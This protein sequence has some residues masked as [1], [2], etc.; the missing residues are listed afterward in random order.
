[1][2]FAL[3]IFTILGSYPIISS[4][5]WVIFPEVTATPFC[6]RLAFLSA[7][8]ILITFL[9]TK[10]PTSTFNLTHWFILCVLYCIFTFKGTLNY[11]ILCEIRLI[12]ISLI[13]L[14]WGYQPERS[15]AFSYI[16]IYTFCFAL[17]LLAIII[18]VGS[19]SNQWVISQFDII[20][21]SNHNEIITGFKLILIIITISSFIVKFPIYRVHLWLP[22]AH[23]E[24]PVSG[25]IILAGLLLKIGGFGWFLIM[26]LITS[27]PR[28]WVFTSFSLMGGT[29]IRLA[30]LRQVD[31][32]VIIAY[33]SVAHLGLVI[34]AFTSDRSLGF[35]G[36]VLIILTHGLSSPG[37]FYSANVFYSRSG[38]RNILINS[39]SVQFTPLVLIFWFF[40]CIANMRAPPSSNLV[41]ELFVISSI[42][43]NSVWVIFQIGFIIL[44]AGAYTLVLYSSSSQGQKKSKARA[45]TQMRQREIRVF[46]TIVVIVYGLSFI[47]AFL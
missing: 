36:G 7:L 34:G 37:I 15:L 32:K 14:G 22:K 29:L 17:P 24:A 12:P 47:I 13:I 21:Q 35:V 45:L 8:V 3:C 44:L 41:A 16:F 1:M 39:G 46:C 40:L 27:S 42:M 4:L 19:Q 20:S 23:V 10:A 43:N 5:E 6:L 31:M 28:M 26:P 18:L 30:C 38:S 2:S 25:S 33:S 9:A 11:F